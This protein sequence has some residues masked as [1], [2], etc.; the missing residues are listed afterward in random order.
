MHEMCPQGMSYCTLKDSDSMERM[1]GDFSWNR[2]RRF[3]V[4]ASGTGHKK[5][6]LKKNIGTYLPH[7]LAMDA[8][9]AELQVSC[10]FRETHVWP[11]SCYTNN[12]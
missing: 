6:L 8:E 5:V 4:K 11:S 12:R 1:E 7:L 2:F 9:A 10:R 3:V